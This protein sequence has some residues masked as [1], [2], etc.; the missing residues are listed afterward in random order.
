MLVELP[1]ILDSL[2][3]QQSISQLP[4]VYMSGGWQAGQTVL[5]AS[6]VSKLVTNMIS[7]SSARCH[8][9]LA[10]GHLTGPRNKPQEKQT[11]EL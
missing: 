4:A 7:Q 11:E 2:L 9:S 3:A 10:R 5:R 1:A 8:Q 6:N